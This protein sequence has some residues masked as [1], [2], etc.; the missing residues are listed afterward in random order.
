MFSRDPGSFQQDSR[1]GGMHSEAGRS[2]RC[3]SSNQ[4]KDNDENGQEGEHG[5]HS[6]AGGREMDDSSLDRS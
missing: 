5:G 2:S 3:H 4:F 1:L 6:K